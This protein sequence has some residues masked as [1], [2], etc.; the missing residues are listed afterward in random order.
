MK[1]KLFIVNKF[2]KAKTL[3]EALRKESKHE[4]DEIF[5][6]GDWKKA[7]LHNFESKKRIG[8][9]ND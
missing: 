4:P 6:D 1:N 2:I 7:N 8:F 3:E 9:N 5:V